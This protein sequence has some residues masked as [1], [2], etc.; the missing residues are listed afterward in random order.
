MKFRK[1]GKKD[2]A[3]SVNT[4]YPKSIVY[5]FEFHDLD[6]FE[7]SVLDI[8][9]LAITEGW[10]YQIGYNYRHNMLFT[11]DKLALLFEYE[12][13]ELAGEF[14]IVFSNFEFGEGYDPKYKWIENKMISFRSGSI[15]KSHS[16]LIKDI[17]KF[18]H[19][20]VYQDIGQYKRIF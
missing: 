10:Q 12:K 16:K 8:L 11:K 1:L 3:S 6:D 7:T 4:E 20:H 13:E 2:P 17:T 18:I 14:K 15:E 9:N 19:H 5:P